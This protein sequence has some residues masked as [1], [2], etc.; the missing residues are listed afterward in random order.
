MEER[1]REALLR[2]RDAYAGSDMITEQ[3]V[4]WIKADAVLEGVETDG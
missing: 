1:L 3:A 2:L 4:A